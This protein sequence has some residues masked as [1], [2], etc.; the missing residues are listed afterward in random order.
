[1]VQRRPV[2][3]H[4]RD[5]ASKWP[6]KAGVHLRGPRVQRCRKGWEGV[7]EREGGV[8]RTRGGLRVVPLPPSHLARHDSC[9][10]P[11]SKSRGGTPLGQTFADAQPHQLP[12]TPPPA[13]ALPPH[14]RVPSVA[15][16]GQ[17]PQSPTN[18][19]SARA[20]HCIRHRACDRRRVVRLGSPRHDLGGCRHAGGHAGGHARTLVPYGNA[21]SEY[22]PAA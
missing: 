12:S 5:P 18:A 14:V 4:L 3:V 10:H 20:S 8:L 16:R 7:G 11:K 1:M 6:S 9:K 21:A 15:E 13:A 19:P 2:G 17:S 22:G